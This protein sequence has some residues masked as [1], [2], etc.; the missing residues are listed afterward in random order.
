MPRLPV[1]HNYAVPVFKPFTLCMSTQ[2]EC[3]ESV[4]TFHCKDVIKIPI[5]EPVAWKNGI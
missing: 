4:P 2:T 3:I 5:A 1:P